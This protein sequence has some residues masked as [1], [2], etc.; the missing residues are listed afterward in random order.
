M[1]TSSL[2]DGRFLASREDSSS[3]RAGEWLGRQSDWRWTCAIHWFQ[4][5][6]GKRHRGSFAVGSR[7]AFAI[8]PSIFIFFTGWMRP[9]TREVLIDH[10]LRVGQGR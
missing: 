9:L 4:A 7:V 10:G 3:A 6:Q 5:Q 8:N 2:S 1:D